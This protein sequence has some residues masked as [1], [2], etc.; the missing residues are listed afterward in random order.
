MNLTDPGYE[1][2]TVS[3]VTRPCTNCGEQ[4]EGRTQYKEVDGGIDCIPHCHPCHCA[5]VTHRRL[6]HE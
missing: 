5:W 6:N 3:G 2:F 4:T 1:F